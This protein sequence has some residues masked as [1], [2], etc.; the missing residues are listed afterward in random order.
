LEN[1]DEMICN[2][3]CEGRYPITPK[4]QARVAYIFLRHGYTKAPHKQENDGKKSGK[5]IKDTLENKATQRATLMIGSPYVVSHIGCNIQV[6]IVDTFLFF[7]F[8]NLKS[9][10]RLASWTGHA[11][12]GLLFAVWYHLLSAGRFLGTKLSKNAYRFS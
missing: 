5:M 9:A 10:I 7:N 3:Y 1:I 6:H 2:R 4:Q 8:Q 12:A 11:T